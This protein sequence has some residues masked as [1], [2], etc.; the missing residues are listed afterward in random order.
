MRM[1]FGPQA[2]QGPQ[3]QRTIFRP[4]AVTVRPFR[5]VKIKI[6]HRGATLAEQSLSSRVRLSAFHPIRALCG[7][8]LEDRFGAWAAIPGDGDDGPQCVET[9]HSNVLGQ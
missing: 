7:V 1:V 5:P 8:V 9:G 3:W 6:S 2:R 4:A